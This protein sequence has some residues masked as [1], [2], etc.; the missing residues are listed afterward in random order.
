MKTMYL[1]ACTGLM[2][3]SAC[4][5]QPT[6]VVQG[7][8]YTNACCCNSFIT[9]QA[10]KVF[11]PSAISPNGDLVNDL[12]TIV[13]DSNT[14]CVTNFVV[15]DSNNNTIFTKDTI[16]KKAAT[17]ITWDGRSTSNVLWEGVVKLRA[18]VTDK[19]SDTATI[20]AN[21]CIYNCN[22]NNA[23]AIANKS[24]CTLLDQFSPVT[25]TVSFATND[26][27]FL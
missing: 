12:F 8:S 15:S 3:I 4:G 25:F 22:A 16:Y 14:L 23:T 24:A 11:V 21:T 17:W 6:P 1:F 26:M 13:G 5:P 18:L 19:N 9:A 27:C 10:A 2:L 7:P 20:A